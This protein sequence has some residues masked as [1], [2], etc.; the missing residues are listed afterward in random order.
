M[1]CSCEIL[2]EHGWEEDEFIHSPKCEINL[3]KINLETSSSKDTMN[4]GE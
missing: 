3:K 4:K 2:K 1:N